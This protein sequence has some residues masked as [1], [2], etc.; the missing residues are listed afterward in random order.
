MQQQEQTATPSLA[1]LV[2]CF[3]EDELAKLTGTLPSTLK[4]WRNRGIG[5]EYA[6]YG[7]S[8]LYPVESVKEH[9]MSS[10]KPRRTKCHALI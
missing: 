5:P 1:Q 2:G 8:Y 6:L 9:I 10:I 7:N 4:S 3:N